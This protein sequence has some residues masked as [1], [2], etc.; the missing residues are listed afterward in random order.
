V[1]LVVRPFREIVYT[2]VG[3]TV[4]F[5]CELRLSKN[6]RDDEVAIDYTIQWFDVNHNNQEITDTDTAER[7]VAFH[8]STYAM[9]L[10]A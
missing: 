10:L 7:F 4:V 5:S 1:E 6:E 3:S 2:P 8:L 9:L